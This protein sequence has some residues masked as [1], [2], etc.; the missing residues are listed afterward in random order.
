MWRS[1]NPCSHHSAESP[2]ARIR[3]ITYVNLYA[4]AACVHTVEHWPRV[5]GGAGCARTAREELFDARTPTVAAARSTVR[6]S[7]WYRRGPA[8]IRRC[9]V[10]TAGAYEY[11]PP[12]AQEVAGLPVDSQ[13]LPGVRRGE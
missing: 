12:L 1:S 7:T 8:R 9:R 3:V 5:A 4:F 2:C 13:G 11:G 10:R 6:V